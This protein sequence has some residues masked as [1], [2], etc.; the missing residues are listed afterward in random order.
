VEYR[1]LGRTGL[2][3]SA[4][5]VGT[6]QLSGPV[7]IDGRPDGFPDVGRSAA[8]RTIQACADLGINFVDTAEIYGE[9]EGE[10]RVGEAI[11][12]RRDRW[13][14]STKFGM[15]R[16]PHGERVRDLRAD[17]IPRSLE[18]SLRRLETDYVDLYLYHSVPAPGDLDGTLEALS[19]LREEGKVRAFGVST[20]D[21]GLAATLSRRGVDVVM[22]PRSLLHPANEMA[23]IVRAAMLGGIVRGAF[24]GGRLTGMHFRVPPRFPP[25]D[26][27]SCEGGSDWSRYAA[28]KGCLPPGMTMATLA[29]R[30]VLD[31][32]TTHTISLG[33]T[34]IERFREA[35]GALAAPPLDAGTRKALERLSRRLEGWTFSRRL[36]RA[37]GSRLRALLG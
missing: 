8:V 32:D 35:A 22:F 33:A 1:Q 30:Y 11:R 19:R 23:R 15:R 5:G 3:V 24:A 7:T 28:L 18:G 37:V 20:A 21:A 31:F 34:S 10:R 25:D 27:R 26:V 36:R 13:I 4:L 17:A 6:W 9:G 14:V 12:G 29:L 2:E 16:G